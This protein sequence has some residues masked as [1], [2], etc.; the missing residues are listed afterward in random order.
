MGDHEMLTEGESVRALAEEL[1][2]AGAFAFDVEFVSE[3]RCIPELSLLQLAWGPPESPRTALIDCLAVDAAPV[4]A[5]VGEPAVATVAHAA[6]QD[7]GL[8]RFRFGVRAHNFWDT[9]IAAAFVGLGEQIGYGRLVESLLGIELDKGAQF[10]AWLKRPLSERQL[11]YARA[12]V[13]HLPALWA[14]LR[15]RLERG[16]RLDWVAEESERLAVIAEPLPDPQ[17]AWR[18]IGGARALDP[19]GRGA[20]RALAAWRQQVAVAEN[21]PLGWILPDKALLELARRRGDAT[22]LRG[23]PEPTLRKHAD[24]IAATARAGAATPIRDDSERPPALSPRG[25]AWAGVVTALVQSLAAEADIAARFVATRAEVEAFIAWF[26][27]G[28]DPARPPALLVGWRGRLAGA[29]ALGWLRGDSSV[30]VGAGGA[31]AVRLL[32]QSNR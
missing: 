16:G 31:G 24:A 4:I 8:L 26:E 27:A 13:L 7:L 22:R 11:D 29:A 25:Q 9:Q 28:A 21:R 5:L 32:L 12:D 23:I 6:R 18:E 15:A 17:E 1:A 2:A 20:L 19:A 10:T 30:A 3:G 14:E